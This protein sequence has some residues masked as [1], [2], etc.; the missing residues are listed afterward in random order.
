MAVIAPFHETGVARV[1]SPLLMLLFVLTVLCFMT[2]V[3]WAWKVMQ[4]VA[5]TELAVNAAFFPTAESY[6]PLIGLARP[7]I[8]VLMLASLAIILSIRRSSRTKAWFGNRSE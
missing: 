3:T 6:G 4:M 7:T 2:R 8:G 5:V 1:A